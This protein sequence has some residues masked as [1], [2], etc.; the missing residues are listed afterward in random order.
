MSCLNSLDVRRGGKAAA[1][2]KSGFM[3]WAIRMAGDVVRPSRTAGPASTGFL[4]VPALDD[5]NLL[6]ILR[7]QGLRVCLL[8]GKSVLLPTDRRGEVAKGNQLAPGPQLLSKGDEVEL[9]PTALSC[10]VQPVVQI[11]S[12]H[13]DDEAIHRPSSR[14]W[15]CSSL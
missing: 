7:L 15:L 12:I 6:G 13:I 14:D 3:D 11:E 8:P 10:F 1:I 5:L 2:N 9:Q 4:L